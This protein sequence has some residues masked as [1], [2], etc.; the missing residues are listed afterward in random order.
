MSQWWTGK[1]RSN[2][3]CFDYWVLTSVVT[4]FQPRMAHIEQPP[5]APEVKQASGD[6]AS[7]LLSPSPC[8]GEQQMKQPPYLP[9]TYTLDPSFNPQSPPSEPHHPREL[10]LG[11]SYQSSTEG[12][13]GN[14][15]SSV[16]NLVRI[17]PV[18]GRAVVAIGLSWNRLHFWCAGIWQ[19]HMVLQ[20]GRHLNVKLGE[21]VTYLHKP[22]PDF[23]LAAEGCGIQVSDFEDK[24]IKRAFIRKVTYIHQCLIAIC[25]FFQWHAL[26]TL[27]LCLHLKIHLPWQ[28]IDKLD[29]QIKWHLHLFLNKSWQTDFSIGIHIIFAES[30]FAVFQTVSLTCRAHFHKF[31]GKNPAS[32]LHSEEKLN[33][34]K[35]HTS[36][37]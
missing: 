1:Q 37:S 23:N 22:F 29:F 24:S 9:P 25:I 26:Y 12:Q 17:F 14:G 8:V 30:I 6:M 35:L 33:N 3:E 7:L 11:P 13:L 32:V 15:V 28:V 19:S 2:C 21:K 5:S 10:D 20:C 18:W 36:V 4:L 31:W 27:N 34:S 16:S